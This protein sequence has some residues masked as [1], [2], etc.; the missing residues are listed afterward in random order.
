[1]ADRKHGFESRWGHQT[2][3]TYHPSEDAG[4]GSL[5]RELVPGLIAYGSW[6]EGNASFE[7]ASQNPSGVWHVTAHKA[8]PVAKPLQH[9]LPVSLLI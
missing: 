4:Q 9:C 8:L 5:A 7:Q 2:F 3:C 6:C 1:V